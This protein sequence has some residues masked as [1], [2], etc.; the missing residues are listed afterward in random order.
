MKITTPVTNIELTHN[1]IL[2][3][4][5]SNELPYITDIQMRGDSKW[6]CSAIQD[7][8]HNL[9][10]L[11]NNYYGEFLSNPDVFISA[12]PTEAFE[13]IVDIMDKNTAEMVVLTLKISY[14]DERSRTFNTDEVFNFFGSSPD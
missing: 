11:N 3:N 4:F 14:G 1:E 10:L 6:A 8:A 2:A 7:L 9:Q 5:L 12:I 13:T